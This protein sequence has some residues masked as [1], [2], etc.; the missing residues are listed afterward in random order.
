[1]TIFI[2]A[3]YSLLLLKIHLHH[4]M[5]AFFNLLVDCEVKCLWKQVSHFLWLI[6]ISAVH[7]ITAI[8]SILF[9]TAS[10]LTLPHCLHCIIVHDSSLFM[11]PIFSLCLAVYTALLLLLP[12]F[13]HCLDVAAAFL[14]LLPFCCNFLIVAS[15]SPLPLP[16]Y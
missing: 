2:A 9:D 4:N 14:F 16:C 3:H 1:M 11:I 13:C 5:Q 12:H 15:A 7:F 10:L 8:A 6:V